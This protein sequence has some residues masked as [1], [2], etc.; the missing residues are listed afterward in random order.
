M[1]LK[2]FKT[3]ESLDTGILN[4]QLSELVRKLEQSGF[5]EI[6]IENTWYEE[7]KE[8]YFIGFV[9]DGYYYF[10]LKTKPDGQ[11]IKMFKMKDTGIPRSKSINIKQVLQLKDVDDIEPKSLIDLINK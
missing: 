6:E 7:N 5:T 3:F 1:R 10:K 8:D 11:T 9:Y 4:K 2:R